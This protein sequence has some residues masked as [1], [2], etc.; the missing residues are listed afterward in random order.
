MKKL[1]KWLIEGPFN[2]V[3]Q[4]IKIINESWAGLN[5]KGKRFHNY[6]L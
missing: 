6:Y 3:I 2:K 4:K 5:S 1:N